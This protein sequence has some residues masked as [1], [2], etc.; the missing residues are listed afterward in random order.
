MF[1]ERDYIL[2]AD[3][4]SIEHRRKEKIV[5]RKKTKPFLLAYVQRYGWSRR[6]IFLW[7]IRL[8]RIQI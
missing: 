7:R 5:I 4:L 8:C 2:V 6:N 3:A 1:G